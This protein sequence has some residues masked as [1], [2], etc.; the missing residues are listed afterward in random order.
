MYYVYGENSEHLNRVNLQ[1]GELERVLDASWLSD[2]NYDFYEDYILYSAEDDML[3]KYN[4]EESE[5][6]FTPD[7]IHPGE[8]FNLLGIQCQDGRIFVEIGLGAFYE[9]IVEIDIDGNILN[10]IPEKPKE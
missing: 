5:V 10:I 2:Y 4:G 3:C 1:T 7:D 8:I 6:V 9:E